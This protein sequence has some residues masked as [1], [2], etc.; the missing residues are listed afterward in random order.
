MVLFASL[1]VVFTSA[2]QN[3]PYEIDDECYRLFTRAELLL[4]SP[5]FKAAN[6]SLMHRAIACGD[7]K[8]QTLFYVERMKHLSRLSQ[9]DKSVTDQM[10]VAAAEELRQ[11]AL[12]LGYKQYYYYSYDLL[13]T[14]YYRKGEIGKTIATAKQLLDISIANGDEYGRW[15][16]SRFMI[17]L[18]LK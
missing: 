4:G 7:K 2:A 13:E 5:E 15:M 17:S 6:D 16:S 12:E 18:Y 14:Y 11:V 10:M 8:S 3:N 9:N 1:A